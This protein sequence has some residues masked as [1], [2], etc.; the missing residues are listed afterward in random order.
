MTWEVIS[1][2]EKPER[3]QEG[4]SR[5]PHLQTVQESDISEGKGAEVEW[6]ES[7]SLEDKRVASK[8][9]AAGKAISKPQ[10]QER[11]HFP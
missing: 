7:K 5:V 8:R 4:F 6:T 2:P 10:S 1:K 9:V 11:R 3:I